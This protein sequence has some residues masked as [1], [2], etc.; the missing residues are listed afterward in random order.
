MPAH[1]S[2]R[3]DD[4]KRRS[5]REAALRYAQKPES[6]TK[7]RE[8]YLKVCDTTEFKMQR[9]AERLKR[10]FN[11]S[12]EQY[13]NMIALQ[14]GMCALCGDVLGDCFSR[15]ALSPVVDH[16]HATS[17]VRGVLHR[18]CNSALG[19]FDDSPTLLQKALKYVEKSCVK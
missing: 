9:Y 8:R 19:M 3:T 7:A 14:H 5:R 6:K 11:M 18:R 4:E 1:K 15:T 2:T 16:C 12:L 17:I 13:N 10:D